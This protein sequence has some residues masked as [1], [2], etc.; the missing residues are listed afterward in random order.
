MSENNHAHELLKSQS[1]CI[2]DTIDKLNKII[3]ETEEK[4]EVNYKCREDAFKRLFEV[5]EA[6]KTLGASK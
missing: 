5:E 1:Y 2:L 4:L 3:K 6:L